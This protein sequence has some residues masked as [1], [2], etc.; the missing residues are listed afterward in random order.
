MP[1]GGGGLGGG[2]HGGGGHGGHGGFGG[3]GGFGGGG[4]GPGFGFWGPGPLFMGAFWF[5]PPW[6]R[7]P[8]L[9][10]IFFFLLIITLII[11]IIASFQTECNNGPEQPSSA[12]SNQSLYTFLAIFG[13]IL[14]VSIM[15]LVCIKCM[16]PQQTA[17][18]EE[19]QRPLVS[20]STT[21]IAVVVDVKTV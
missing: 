16:G 2:G 7:H 6:M 21:P 12:C 13:A 20:S 3:R 19:E 5:G 1:P 4:F 14:L 10:S 15:Y 18:E 17:T 8:G 11:I 9:P